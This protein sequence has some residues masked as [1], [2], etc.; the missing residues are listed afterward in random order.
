M[1]ALEVVIE[2]V[3]EAVLA[4]VG[5]EAVTSAGNMKEAVVGL[6]LFDLFTYSFVI[7]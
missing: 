7:F 5:R 2:A 3:L 6:F 1:M 4:V